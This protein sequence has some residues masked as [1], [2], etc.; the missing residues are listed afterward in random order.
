MTLPIIPGS[1]VRVKYHPGVLG[2]YIRTLAKNRA[3]VQFIGPSVGTETVMA[4]TLRPP[5]IPYLDPHRF[6][7]IPLE[8]LTVAREPLEVSPAFLQDYPEFKAVGKGRVKEPPYWA[9]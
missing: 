1:I 2:L 7:A 8:E 5:E 9:Q 6:F 3:L 4:S